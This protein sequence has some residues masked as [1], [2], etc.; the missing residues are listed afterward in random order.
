MLRAGVIAMLEIASVEPDPDRRKRMLTFVVAG[1]GFAGVE[2]VGA[3]NDLAVRASRTTAR[4]IRVKS[5][6]S[7]SEFYLNWRFLEFLLRVDSS[8]SPSSGRMTAPGCQDNTDFTRINLAVVREAL[9][10]EIIDGP[11]GLDAGETAPATTNVS[12]RFRRSGSGS[13][14]AISSIAITPARSMTASPIV[15]MPSACS[16]TPGIPCSLSRPK[17]QNEGDQTATLG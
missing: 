1:G 6:L 9:T 15:F 13:T 4:L 7:C 5:V 17:R 2:T 12:I 11:D 14:L 16:A 10:G 8:A 3:I